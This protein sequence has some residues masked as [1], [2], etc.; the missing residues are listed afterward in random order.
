[1][2]SYR[3]RENSGLFSHG[4]LWSVLVA[5]GALCAFF[6]LLSPPAF[7]QG[8]AGSISGVVRDASG[9]VVPA[10]S[11]TITNTATGVTTPTQTNAEGLYTFPYVQPGVYDLTVSVPGFQT[12]KK[13]GVIVN[14]TE[15][16]QVSFD[17]N[18]GKVEQTVEVT[19]ETSL[20]DT[21]TATAGQTIDRRFVNDLPLLNRTALDLAYL[22][23]GTAQAPGSAYGTA[24][25]TSTTSYQGANNFV[26]NGSR[27]QTSDT[28]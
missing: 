24:T 3:N 22:A 12:L 26:S 4:R 5:L 23:P 27:N 10:A 21:S 1:M 14:V 7:A 11:V 28:L 25:Q 9:A 8:A 20:L 6:V 15:R 13:P 18:V 16:V 19:A 17:L 2:N